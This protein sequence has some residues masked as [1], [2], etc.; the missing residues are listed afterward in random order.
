MFE[1]V[2]FLVEPSR[3]QPLQI[4]VGA[5]AY[6]ADG[7]S[8]ETLLVIADRRMYRDKSLR[9]RARVRIGSDSDK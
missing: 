3:L 5:A 4:S 6:P 2:R 9:K 1:A 7:A 8:L